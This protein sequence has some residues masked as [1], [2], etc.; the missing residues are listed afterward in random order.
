MI[1]I[2]PLALICQEKEPSEKRLKAKV[3]LEALKEKII[4]QVLAKS[5]TVPNQ[6][7]MWNVKRYSLSAVFL[8]KNGRCQDEIP[9]DCRQSSADFRE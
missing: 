3:V 9:T 6:I 5:T 4:H 2:K 8:R 7:S 1:G